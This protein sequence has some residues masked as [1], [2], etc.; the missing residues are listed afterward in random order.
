MILP[1]RYLVRRTITD[2]FEYDPVALRVAFG[3]DNMTDDDVLGLFD[4]HDGSQY[5]D[6]LF[7][8]TA[9]TSVG[10]ELVQREDDE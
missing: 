4:L 2:E 7:S 9:D 1:M 3:S 6:T 8:N 10:V 5:G